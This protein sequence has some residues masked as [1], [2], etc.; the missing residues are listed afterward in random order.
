MPRLPKSEISVTEIEAVVHAVAAKKELEPARTEAWFRERKAEL[1]R[2]A[3]E[4]LQRRLHGSESRSIRSA[5][6]QHPENSR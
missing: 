6:L 3:D 4:I 5:S 1:K 2:Q